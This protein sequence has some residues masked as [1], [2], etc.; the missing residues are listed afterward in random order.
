M[1]GLT[2]APATGRLIAELVREQ[3]THIDIDA[4][5]PDRF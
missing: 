3:A 1:L 2:L 5:S 4:F